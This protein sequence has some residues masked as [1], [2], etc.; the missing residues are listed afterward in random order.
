MKN[1][2]IHIYAG[3][4]KGKTTAGCG[5][6]L[7]AL[8]QGFSVKIFSFLKKDNT[9]EINVFKKLENVEIISH[10]K[11]HQLYFLLSDEER[12]AV[13]EEV[14]DMFFKFRDI[15]E[16]RKADVILLDEILDCFYLKL[17]DE[18]EFLSV[19][20]N[21]DSCELI[22]TGRNPSEKITDIA[23]YISDISCRRHPYSRG[24]NARRGIEY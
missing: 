7:R 14:R 22:L 9:G 5:L 19:I 3:D 11:E 8:G 23:D 17:I 2:K 1:P 4:G 6:C 21:N 18:N 24:L 13:K 12:E 15:I 16:R 10:P 20:K